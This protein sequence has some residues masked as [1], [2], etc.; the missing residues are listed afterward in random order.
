MYKNE[1]IIDE[2][3]GKRSVANYLGI[4]VSAVYLW[5]FK[6]PKGNEG[7]IPPKQAIKIHKLAQEK[8]L[9]Y[10]IEEILGE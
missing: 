3:G 9:N 6:K 4:G 2:L 5:F 8:G 1:E 10:T 7:R